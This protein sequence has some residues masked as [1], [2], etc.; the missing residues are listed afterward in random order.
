MLIDMFTAEL[1]GTQRLSA[2]EAMELQ[3]GKYDSKLIG[4]LY[5]FSTSGKAAT[6]AAG[7]KEVVVKNLRPGMVL[8]S[9][10]YTNDGV[11]IVP[12]GTKISLIILKKL[13]NFSEM[14]GIKEPI[15]IEQ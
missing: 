13:Y 9:D 8:T 10:I 11:L 1:S 7:S 15:F 14:P 12:T 6:E 3:G 5:A 2:L 4:D